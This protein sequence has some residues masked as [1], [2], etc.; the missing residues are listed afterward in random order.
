MNYYPLADFCIFHGILTAEVVAG[1]LYLFF[2]SFSFPCKV[3]QFL[4]LGA[5]AW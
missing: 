3:K 5:D 1:G 4:I 2:L